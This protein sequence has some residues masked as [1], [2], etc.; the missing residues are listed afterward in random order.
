MTRAHALLNEAL[1]R[2]PRGSTDIH[3]LLTQRGHE[4]N[5]LNLIT[6]LGKVD[7]PMPVQR[8]LPGSTSIDE[9]PTR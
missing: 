3:S 9:V 4:M 7:D 8:L 6:A 2:A 5:L 1:R